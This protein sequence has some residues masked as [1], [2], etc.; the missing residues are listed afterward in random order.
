[1]TG[2]STY[3]I[4]EVQEFLGL[5]RL[6]VVNLIA[7]GFITPA[8][9]RR[10]EFRFTFQ[11]VV[12]LRTAHRLTEENVPLRKV[13]Q[14]L[15]VLRERLP[16]EMPM[17]GLR[18]T[19]IGGEVAVRTADA[20]W[21]A[22]SGQVL[23][24][25]EVTA[26]AASV[27]L[28]AHPSTD[29][30]PVD[31]SAVETAEGH[32]RRGHVLEDEDPSAAEAAYR[33]ALEVDATHT[34]SLLNLGALLCRHGHCDD[35]AELYERALREDP[36]NAALL[37]NL[38]I[39]LEDQKRYAS[40]IAAYERVLELAPDVVDAHYNLGLLYDITGEAQK[41]LRHISAYRRLAG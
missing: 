33:S 40:A 12:V 15:K 6:A 8:R 37:F 5:S 23:I 25:F 35:A 16:A 38:A 22:P 2:Q 32:F 41:A 31:D 21:E 39:A 20:Q 29:A 19:A 11:D 24:D 14:S 17:S 18:I 9:G 27:R 3:T 26:D 34:P 4:G 1:M 13:V 7:A 28:I 30:D 10:N 36:D